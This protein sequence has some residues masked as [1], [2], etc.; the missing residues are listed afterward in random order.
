M[1][2]ISHCTNLQNLVNKYS[3]VN[4]VETG[5]GTGDSMSDMYEV[6]GIGW[7]FGIELDNNLCAELLAKFPTLWL[8]NDYSEAA[9]PKIVDLLNTQPGR[10]TLFWLDAHF[11]N[12]DFNGAPYDAEPVESRRIPLETELRIIVENRDVSKDVIIMDDLR[13]YEEGPFEG[14]SWPMRATAGADN[15]NFVYELL[16]P[17]HDIAKSYIDQGYLIATPKGI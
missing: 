8:W 4:Y 5:V 14:G 12:A 10:P 15:C 16:A 13:I 9:M 2:R 17:T 6:N 3:I 1:G 7:Y 11:P